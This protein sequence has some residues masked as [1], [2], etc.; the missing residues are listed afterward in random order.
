MREFNKVDKFAGRSS[1]KFRDKSSS[2]SSGGKFGRRDSFSSGRDSSS[3][4]GDRP[5]KRFDKGSFA[6]EKSSGF[7]VHETV[8]D[9]CGEKCDVPFKPTGGKPIYCRS[10]FRQNNSGSS[11]RGTGRFEKFEDRHSSD[12]FE[13]KSSISPKELEQINQKLD[14]IMKALKIN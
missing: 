3:K 7:T 9:K 2:R 6:K 10:C 11:D 1:G 8:C 12:R 13:S 4:F 14:K 5:E